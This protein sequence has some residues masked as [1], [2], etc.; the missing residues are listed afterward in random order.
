[1]IREKV[2]QPLVQFADDAMLLLSATGFSGLGG[3][4]GRHLAPAPRS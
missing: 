1:M 4:H 3:D 2:R